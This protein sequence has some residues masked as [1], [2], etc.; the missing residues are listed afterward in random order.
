MQITM[1][2]ALFA[3]ASIGGIIGQAMKAAG[4]SC[5]LTCNPWGGMIVGGIIGLSLAS[6]FGR[7][8]GISFSNNVVEIEN[9]AQLDN[10]L[11]ESDISIIDYYSDSCWPCEQIKPAIHGIADELKGKVKVLALNIDKNKELASKL[12][13]ITIPDVRIY[14]KGMQIERI[15]GARNKEYYLEKIKTVE[16]DQRKE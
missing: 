16:S 9:Q 6:G 15:V 3:G 8:S 14:R 4:G 12:G 10:L 11:K 13:V 7:Q 1:I 2:L 5:P